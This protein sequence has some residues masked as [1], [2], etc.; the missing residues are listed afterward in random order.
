MFTADFKSVRLQFV[1][2]TGLHNYY[3]S[4]VRSLGATL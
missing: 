2:V 3:P 1:D 4:L